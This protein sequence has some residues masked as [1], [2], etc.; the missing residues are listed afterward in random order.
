MQTL[1]F[2]C[3]DTSLTIDGGISA[4]RESLVAVR[5]L[6]VE[7][8]CPQTKIGLESHFS[9]AN[10]AYGTDRKAN[11]RLGRPRGQSPT[12]IPRCAPQFAGWVANTL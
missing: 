4:T 8:R 9:E 10:L 2:A 11:S 12:S 6:H 5:E 1:A 7:L 3:P